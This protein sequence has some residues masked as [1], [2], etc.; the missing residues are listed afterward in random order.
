MAPDE[1]LDEIRR[2]RLEMD[3]E[4]NQ[5][6]DSFFDCF[7]KMQSEFPERLVKYGPKPALDL[8]QKKRAV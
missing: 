2:S 7:Q 6:S 8:I 1:I 5:N 3:E 4:Y